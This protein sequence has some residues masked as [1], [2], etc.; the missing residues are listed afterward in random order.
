MDLFACFHT[1]WFFPGINS[2]GAEIARFC[3]TVGSFGEVR[4]RPIV[5]LLEIEESGIIGAS[6][7]TVPASDTAMMIHDDDTVCTLVGGLH[8]AD[9][10]T[11]RLIALVA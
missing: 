5:I 8:R 1:G 7:H 11:W 2:M 3:D 10:C 4:I 6:D 9:K